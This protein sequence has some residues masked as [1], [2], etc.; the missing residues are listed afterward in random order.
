VKA[1]MRPLL[2][3]AAPAP[4]ALL[5]AAAAAS[6]A[7]LFATA[8]ASAAE[9]AAGESGT[10]APYALA[11]DLDLR[12][13]G[14]SAYSL[15]T[16]DAWGGGARMGTRLR[17]GGTY[18]PAPRLTL[19]A[20]AD[21]HAGDVYGAFP[22]LPA[23]GWTA[24]RTGLLHAGPAAVDLRHLNLTLETDVGL[25]RAGQMGSHWGLGMVA[26]GGE[27]APLWGVARHGALV[28]RV[29][30]A[31]RPLARA[32]LGTLGE[33]VIVAAGGDLVYRDDNADL[34]AGDRA[35]QGIVSTLYREIEGEREIGVYLAYRHQTDRPDAAGLSAVMQVLVTDVYG[36]WS[37]TLGDD[38]V[39][40]GAAEAALMTGRTDRVR[41]DAHPDG[42]R[43]RSL[44]WVGHVTA[45]LQGLGLSAGW[46]AGYASGDNDPDDHTMRRMRFASD[47]RP[48]LVL[49]EHL[50][51]ESTAG[52]YARAADP[53]RVAVPPAGSQFLPTGGAVAGASFTGP[54][55]TWSPNGLT[56]LSL[57]LGVLYATATADVIDPYATF[58]NGGVATNAWGQRPG[59]RNLGLEVDLG[60]RYHRALQHGMTVGA[61]VEA[62]RL[63]PGNAFETDTGRLPPIT[64][65]Y[66]GG[67]FAWRFE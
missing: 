35:F 32:N 34:L 4:A 26:N 37:H 2:R 38:V 57:A 5:R 53:G 23:G 6:A 7:L 18:L 49:F 45:D 3:A 54:Q 47:F 11:V 29:V 33:R 24:R 30:F 48:A 46:W 8:P 52:A 19:A 43:I 67:T 20:L 12:G 36:A 60:L 13:G 62:G 1:L 59:G 66:T 15:D 58:A 41:P 9:P 14:V 10:D 21:I 42:V 51:A 16:T 25:L 61:T 63:W 31:T 28:E 56:G 64:A 65:V 22:E 50:L 39:L 27:R 44:G 55:I 17:F 40:R